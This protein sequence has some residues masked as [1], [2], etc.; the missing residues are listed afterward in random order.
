MFTPEVVVVMSMVVTLTGLGDPRFSIPDRF[1]H[2]SR[3]AVEADVT[4]R[5]AAEFA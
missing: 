5:Q 2:P 3:H 1:S 4:A